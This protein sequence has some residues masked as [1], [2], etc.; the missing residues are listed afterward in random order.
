[1]DNNSD[2]TDIDNFR[3]MDNNGRF[4]RLRIVW[5]A[6]RIPPGKLRHCWTFMR[7]RQLTIIPKSV[8]LTFT[9][10]G[11]LIAEWSHL[12]LKLGMVCH[13]LGRE[14]KSQWQQTLSWTQSQHLW[15]SWLYLGY[16]IWKYNFSAKFVIWIVK[17]KI[18]N[19]PVFPKT[20]TEIGP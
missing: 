17:Q 4:C 13:I 19:K 15:F 7:K 18:E 14:Y 2:R 3:N 12:A 11:A 9:N 8:N 16:F 5:L 20:V 10:W 1:M 6:V